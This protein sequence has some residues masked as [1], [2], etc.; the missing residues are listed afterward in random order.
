[1]PVGYR[2]HSNCAKLEELGGNVAESSLG[3]SVPMTF[4]PMYFMGPEGR[5]GWL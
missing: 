3:V 1:M 4:L 5:L 2:M